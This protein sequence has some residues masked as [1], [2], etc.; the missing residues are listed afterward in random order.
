M[1]KTVRDVRIAAP[2]TIFHHTGT[3]PIA[4]KPEPEPVLVGTVGV[5]GGLWPLT[6]NRRSGGPRGTGTS[7]PE[8]TRIPA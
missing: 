6:P 3:R 1:P 2:T 8:P 4:A 5:T 7:Q